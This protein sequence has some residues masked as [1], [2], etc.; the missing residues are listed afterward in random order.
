MEPAATETTAALREG[1]VTVAIVGGAFVRIHQHVVGFA[2]FL[3]IFFRLGVARIF[4]RMKFD[5]EFAV[6]ALDFLFRRFA[7]D[8]KHFVIIA[9]RDRHFCEFSERKPLVR[10]PVRSKPP[11]W[12]AATSDPSSDSRDASGA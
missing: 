5:R 7:A 8:G 12:K 9:F 1:G 4:V 11:H 2:E 6:R 3:E 10:Q